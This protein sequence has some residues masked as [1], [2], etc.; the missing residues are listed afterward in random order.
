MIEEPLLF[1]TSVWVHYLR[2]GGM[3]S[4]QDAVDE[5]LSHRRAAICWVVTAEILV[6]TR[7]EAEFKTA[8]DVMSG[9]PQVPVTD[10]V[11]QEAARV[12]YRMRR[13]GVS[14]GLPDLVIAQCAIASGRT[15]WHSDRHFEYIQQHT[16]LQARLW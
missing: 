14:I 8:S 4:L 15:L 9:L 16:A 2:S 5:A 10:D 6:G 3:V 13:A 11:W 7:N 12:G 1:D